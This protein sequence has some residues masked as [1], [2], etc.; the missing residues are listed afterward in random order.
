M[1]IAFEDVANIGGAPW[2]TRPFLWTS[3][4]VQI[5]TTLLSETIYRDSI[6]IG[7]IG[8]WT[9]FHRHW[10]HGEC[11][12]YRAR[13]WARRLVRGFERLEPR[14]YGAPWSVAY[15]DDELSLRRLWWRFALVELIAGLLGRAQPRPAESEGPPSDGPRSRGGRLVWAALPDAARSAQSAQRAQAERSRS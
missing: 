6:A 13:R 10:S 12:G 15:A 3:G 11:G 1:R 7:Q 9:M 5:E 14:K 8:G 2:R 4:S